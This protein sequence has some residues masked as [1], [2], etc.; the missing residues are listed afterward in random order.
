MGRRDKRHVLSLCLSLSL[1]VCVCPPPTQADDP[2][3]IVGHRLLAYAL[4]VLHNSLSA[5]SLGKSAAWTKLSRLRARPM[6]DLKSFR[7]WGGPVNV[8]R[9]L[10]IGRLMVDTQDSAKEHLLSRVSEWVSEWAEVFLSS[11]VLC[12]VVLRRVR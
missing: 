11:C 5:S 8:A 10:T 2:D 6:R 4:G 7:R 3:I 12:C 1:C 9:N